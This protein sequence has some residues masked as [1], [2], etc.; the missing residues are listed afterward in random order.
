[1]SSPKKNVSYQSND[2]SMI[3][4]NSNNDYANKTFYS[5]ITNSRYNNPNIN[6]RIISRDNDLNNKSFTFRKSLKLPH[7]KQLYLK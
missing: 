1:M 4:S 7:K 6:S 5:N 3:D 2:T